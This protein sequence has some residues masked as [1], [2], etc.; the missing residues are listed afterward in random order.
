[1]KLAGAEA[2]RYCA[3]P[4]PARAGLLIFG[5][6][7]MR[8]ALKR[9]E[10][11][12]A[13]IGPQ[14]EGEMRLTRIQASDLRKDASLL[15]DATRAVGF[16]PGP[17]VA[18][19]EEATDGLTATIAEALQGWQKGDAQIVVTAGN[20]TGKSTLKTLFEKHLNA[21]SIGLYDDPPTR[22]EIEAELA[23]AGLKNIPPEAMTDLTTLARA[24]D[25]G[26]FRQTLE[27]I[28]L[29]KYGDSTPLTPQEIHDLAP[30]TI[31]AEVDDLL[32]AVADQNANA[33]GPLMRRLEGQGVLPITLCI[34]ALRHFRALHVAVT[35][36]GG[37]GSG[38]MKA[39]V[40]GPRR[41]A[42][43]RQAGSWGM[44]KLETALSLLIETDMT[45]RST[46]RA[47]TMAVMERALIRLAM[48][49]R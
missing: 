29:Y 44:H 49:K 42:M 35:D 36:P 2:S 21:V 28:A 34:G 23:K 40:F 47:P 15:A 30:A 45:L 48:M 46:S 38:L 39:R 8:V 5:A 3:K 13:L 9:Q 6:D 37:I 10:A 1:M 11:I 41:D 27:K 26:D 19:V 25:P 17:R 12:A 43:Q 14:G 32:A 20:L 33:I 31:E 18:F 4:D 22:E 16:F 7:T 24:L